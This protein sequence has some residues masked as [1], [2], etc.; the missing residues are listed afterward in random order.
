[1]G[2]ENTKIPNFAPSLSKLLAP[3][4]IP[5]AAWS[6]PKNLEAIVAAVPEL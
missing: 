3:K 5:G 6:Y 2:P 4:T 1:M